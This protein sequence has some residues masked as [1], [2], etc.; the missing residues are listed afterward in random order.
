MRTEMPAFV[1]IRELGAGESDVL[2]AVFD[3][4][5]M[6]SRF[7]RFHAGVTTLSP[8]MRD[9][10]TA[11]DGYRHIAVA[12]FACGEPIGIAR[13]VAVGDGPMELAVEVVDAWQRRGVGTRLVRAV[14]ERGRAVGHTRI[15][16]D[17]LAENIAVQLVL[18]TVFPT[19]VALDD[20]PEIRFTADLP[21]AGV[22]GSRAA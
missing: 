1:R 2:D 9:R 7:R 19:L 4:L 12:A 22:P 20:G 10:L 6:T 13:L 17:V 16:A 14:A 5:S 18:T 3:G 15:V 21:A 11:V 8:R